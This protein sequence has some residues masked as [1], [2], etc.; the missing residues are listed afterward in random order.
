[1][2]R[3]R[4]PL[5][6]LCALG[7]T[8]IV[9]QDA[10]AWPTR[11]HRRCSCPVSRQSP[12]V[13]STTVASAFGEE[14]SPGYNSP[15][16]AFHVY[17]TGSATGNFDQMLSALTPDSRGYHVGLAVISV[18]YLFEKDAGEKLL[19]D[20][21]PATPPQ[22]ISK[23]DSDDTVFVKVMLAVRTP[24]KL[25]KAIAQRQEEI[26]QQF[27]KIA[28]PHDTRKRPTAEQLVAS[29][30]L[31]NVKVNGSTAIADVVVNQPAKDYLV[32]K[33]ELLKVVKFRQ[34]DDRWYCD[35]D[36]R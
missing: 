13:A 2:L 20:Y 31:K 15:E 16:S 30:I 1:M 12:A 24:G 33:Q 36:P 4:R 8:L 21:L 34:I 11:H 17:V 6:G 9:A 35:I 29:I 28:P 23:D 32:D 26:A 3:Y 10:V 19:R 25:M 7:I 5:F 27:A 18:G 22:A 14:N